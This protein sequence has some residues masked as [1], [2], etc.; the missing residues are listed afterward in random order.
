MDQ[1]FLGHN[2]KYLGSFRLPTHRRDAHGNFFYDVL[3]L[4]GVKG[5]TSIIYESSECEQ[6]SWETHLG[7]IIQW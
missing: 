2:L 7:I 1:I 5:L 6:K 4:Q 3:V